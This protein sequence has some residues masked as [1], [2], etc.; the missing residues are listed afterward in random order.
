[1]N[2]WTGTEFAT[3]NPD[4]FLVASA[5]PLDSGF[6][7]QILFTGHGNGAIAFN[8]G[9]GLYEIVPV[10]EPA[11]IFGAIGLVAFV[12]FRERRRVAR[13]FRKAA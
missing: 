5:G 3:G 12:G 11:T 6:L 8:V 2:N 13:M 4:Q 9:G 7:G 10:P 1:M